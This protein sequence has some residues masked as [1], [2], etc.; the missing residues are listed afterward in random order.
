MYNER[1]KGI[2][3]KSD[4]LISDAMHT[5]ADIFTSLSV[6]VALVVIKLGY[7]ILDP[8]VTIMISLFITFAGWQIV[9]ESSAVLCDTVAILDI[10]KITDIVLR[11]EGVKN[12][13]KIRSRGRPDDIHV[14]LHV[15]VEGNMHINTSHKICYAIENAIKE[16][17]PEITDVV[18]HIEPKENN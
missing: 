8:I 7:P 3:L 2:L 9:K 14:D 10:N 13:H 5:T 15:Q 11:I 12:C 17:I 16:N 18:V 6:I 4:I 1:K